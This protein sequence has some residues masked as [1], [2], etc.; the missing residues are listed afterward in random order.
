M[1][2][3]ARAVVGDAPLQGAISEYLRGGDSF[4]VWPAL[5]M[6]DTLLF[7]AQAEGAER[8][9]ESGFGDELLGRYFRLENAE[10]KL[11][12][13][14][15]NRAVK[16]AP[17]L[18]QIE[19]ERQRLGRDLHTGVGQLLAAIRLQLEVIATQI[20]NPAEPVQKALEHIGW[21]SQEALQQVRGI[22]QR[23]YP[24]EWQRLTIEDALRQ[25]WE[26]TGI[27]QRFD[28]KIRMEPLGREPA[29]EIKVLL[30][31]AAQEALSNIARHSNASRVEMTLETF[32]DRIVLTMND[33]G[34]G[35]ERAGNE[36][37]LGLR[38]TRDAA[39]EVGATFDV[40]S[41]P[42]STTLRVSAPFDA[43]E[44]AER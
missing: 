14:R 2:R 44:S 9:E 37:G 20:P 7:A 29:Q 8:A 42:G 35:F 32:S 33:N 28:A 3:H 41:A 10:R 27:P 16:G 13:L 5:I 17:A 38:S 11:A 31:R 19:R 26:A 22:S 4:R 6:Q 18:R 15:R 21:L 40:E 30:Y 43:N 39:A 25:L 34:R 23:L 12:E 36:S 24:P 1:S